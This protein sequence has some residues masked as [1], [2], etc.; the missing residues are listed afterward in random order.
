MT[1]DD[2]DTNS[3]ARDALK[4]ARREAAAAQARLAEVA[5]RY[6]DL[7]IGEEQAVAAGSTVAGPNRPRPGE[8]VADE[9][10]ACWP[11]PVASPPACLPSGRH[12]IG[13][14]STLNRSG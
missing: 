5:V 6:A 4:Q 14:I 8:F 1:G 13:A 3:L 9:V 2:L 7:R 12:S 11:G 10:A